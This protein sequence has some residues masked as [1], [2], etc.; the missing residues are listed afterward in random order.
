MEVKLETTSLSSSVTVSESRSATATENPV[1][2]E[3]FPHPKIP[4]PSKQLLLPQKPLPKTLPLSL[5]S[6]ILYL[7]SSDLLSV[8]SFLT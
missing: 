6:R 4:F 1:E 5:K 8:L 7:R 3:P 2:N